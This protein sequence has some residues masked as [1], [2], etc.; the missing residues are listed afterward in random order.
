[1]PSNAGGSVEAMRLKLYIFVAGLLMPWLMWAQPGRPAISAN[2]L[3]HQAVEN[4][5]KH[6]A[7]P[8][9]FLFRQRT[10]KPKGTQVKQ[11]IETPQGMIGRLVS[12]N[13]HPLSAEERRLD[14]ERI[15]RLLDPAKM[16][17]KQEEQRKDA[18]RVRNMI[19]SLDDAFNYEYDGTEPGPNGKTFTRMKF[20]PNPNFNPP[21]RE[22][23]LLQGMNGV[24]V[25]D[26]N[27][28]RIVKIDGTLF[29]D[30]TFGW[31]LLGRLQS[32]GRFVVAQQEI[33]SGHWEITDLTLDFV[34]KAL[35]VKSIKIQQKQ[36][37]SDFT[38]V[39]DNLSVAK[40]IEILKNP[41]IL[42]ADKR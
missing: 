38:R 22:T 11:I 23:A 36:K 1:M 21:T 17:E 40:A 41:D 18:Q 34:G 20:T 9:Y 16:R 25:V 6:S 14:D 8:V 33:S 10:E 19:A 42:V 30:V 15:N 28:K 2:E 24:M 27:Q 31:G 12:I 35:M 37:Y 39:P 26:P 4:E 32:G 29:R 3:A 5:H 7:D 13:D